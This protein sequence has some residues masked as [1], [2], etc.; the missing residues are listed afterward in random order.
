MLD[1]T[2]NN[3]KLELEGFGM[4]ELKYISIGDLGEFLEIIY[5]QLINPKIS[6]DEFSRVSDSDLIKISGAFIEKHRGYEFK[7]F[8][9]TGDFFKDF[10]NALKIANEK[11]SEEF[12]KTLVPV[13][14]SVQETLTAFNKDYGSLIQQTIGAVSYINK[15]LLGISNIAEQFKDVQLK[16][17][18][19]LKPMIEGCQ[20][21]A[22]IVESFRP[23]IDFWQ[24]WTEQN[25]RT[26]SDK[27]S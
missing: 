21:F 22:R 20:S 26:Q 6:M 10:L 9:D 15:S 3:T 4:I 5:H 23:Q 16:A 8:N 24:K 1:F 12:K 17:A 7:Y 2:K 18:E 11:Q 27:R 14:K 13:I 25:S 19:S